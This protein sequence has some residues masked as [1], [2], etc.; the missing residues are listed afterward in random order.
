MNTLRS[1]SLLSL[2]FLSAA[3]GARS[4]S[5][6]V[7]NGSNTNWLSGCTKDAK[8]GDGICASGACT[9]TCRNDDDCTHLHPDAKCADA[10]PFVPNETTA[11]AEVEP[12]RVCTPSCDD[13]DDCSDIGDGYTCTSGACVPVACVNPPPA[14]PT[15]A[16][17][18]ALEPD[19]CETRGCVPIEGLALNSC[20]AMPK[21]VGCAPK[22]SGDAALSCALDP[23]DALCYQF[24]TTTTP[25][26]WTAVDCQ[27][28]RCAA[29]GCP[30]APC[31][32]PTENLDQAYGGDIP[33]CACSDVGSACVQGVALICD[34][35]NWV[36]VED[37]PCYPQVTVCDGLL[38]DI[39]ECIGLFDSCT[40]EGD[41][42][43]GR[44][45]RTAL[46][47]GGLLV[48][49]EQACPT[50]VTEC[51]QLDNGFWCA[52]PLA[53]LC[54]EH[55]EPV[56]SCGAPDYDCREAEDPFACRLRSI[57]VGACEA[58]GGE[59]FTDPGDGSLLQEGCPPNY[60]VMGRLLPLVEGGLCCEPGVV[61]G[62]APITEQ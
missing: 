49:A 34:A 14:T 39:T 46:C 43:C 38:D 19:D 10:V 31:F 30:I 23:G 45:S 27:D 62:G 53:T 18:A 24:P 28:S 13:E 21:P 12:R 5:N 58:E 36:A 54:P 22:D 11:C 6:N 20:G 4:T 61:D 56:T 57:E 1:L 60:T 59:V 51:T 41:R 26:G 9:E 37:G 32:S 47:S 17:C 7:G 48:E 44:G 16:E 8:C 2:V 35:G 15:D 29:P 42:Y 3:C 40:A 50:G 33:G 55:F 25:S 52:S